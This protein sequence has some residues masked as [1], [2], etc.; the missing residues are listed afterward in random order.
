MKKIG[1][2]LGVLAGIVLLAA[3]VGWM[4]PAD[5]TATRRARYARPPA[6][7]FEVVADFSS[8]S[9]W[10]TGVRVEVLDDETF[11]EH[12][13]EGPVRM[14][15]AS[16][17]PPTRL[18]VAIDDPELPFSGTW[19]Y[20]LAPVDGGTELVITERGSISNPLI[21]AMAAAFFDPGETARRYL[22]DL[23]AHF[24]EAVVPTP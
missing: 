2:A 17:E 13:E 9:S 12:T 21:R 14:R 8:A 15:V 4:L 1:I 22:V 20:E 11:V 5:H 18:I 19:T 23:G 7:V 10:R 6:E 16:R 3:V 24:G